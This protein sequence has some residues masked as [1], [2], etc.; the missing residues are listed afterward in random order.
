MQVAGARGRRLGVRRSRRLGVVIVGTVLGTVVAVPA[1]AQVPGPQVPRVPSMSSAAQESWTPRDARYGVAVE[2]DIPI[3]MSDGNVLYADVY[4]PAAANGT[5]APGRFPTLLT[6]TPYNKNAMNPS[7]PY[8]VSRGYVDVVADVRGTGS[9]HGLQPQPYHERE[10]R[11][12]YELVEWAAAQPWSTARVGLHGGSYLGIN[13]LLTAIQQPPALRAIFPV[14][15]TGDTYRS[16][17]PGG[18]LTSL[19]VFSILVFPG[20][21]LL[22]P[23]Y[24]AEDPLEA[25]T[26]LATRPLSIASNSLNSG[27]VLAGTDDRFDGPR[28][29]GI[30]PLRSID[31]ID[32][33]TFLVGGWYDALSQRDAPLMFQA[34]QQRRV[35]A[36]LLMGPWYHVTAGSELPAD[37]VPTLDELQLRWFDH[38]VAGRSDPDLERWG[39]VFY[40]S[41]GEDHYKQSPTWPPPGVTYQQRFLSGPAAPGAPGR[42]LD[43]PPSA[44]Q[45]ADALPWQPASGI[46]TRSMYD[47]TFGIPPSTPCETDST[48]ND[49]TG[50][51]YDVPVT[52]PLTLA[53]P[54][55]A[56][57]FVSS[58]RS[59]AHLALRIEDVDPVT[60]AV[61]EI[62]A[63]WDTLS[64]RALDDARS[65]IVDGL[66]VLPFHPYTK[67]SVL[68]VEPNTVYE[69]WVSV[70]PTAVTIPAGH[71]L[72]VSVQ[73][74]DAV[75]FL[76][77]AAALDDLA[78]SV[79]FIHHD[80]A[81]P[82]A[83][84]LPMHE[85]DG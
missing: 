20:L 2:K 76:P 82:S 66:Y 23:Q 74:S 71:V 77:T 42:L 1:P 35:P 78:G 37:G 47:G 61:D 62:T 34:L 9:S 12:G 44:P 40:N 55:S 75:R 36:K 54:I 29:D 85:G 4:R 48:A 6:Q 59:D 67:E 19:F 8:L 10:R 84:V 68:P 31:R 81:H 21:G 43:T 17:S 7:S 51:T 24:L 30:S 5:P 38:Y 73:P 80:A 26:V 53:G 3:T 18:Y 13:Q 57:L 16:L 52:S 49:L 69:W 15:P 72:R 11:D 50:L 14:I 58:S 56:R 25:M 41:L 63:G 60:G 79:F 27:S 28:N 46:C 39:P 22:P 32:V 83:V 33:P 64:F 45:A 70:F 65:Q